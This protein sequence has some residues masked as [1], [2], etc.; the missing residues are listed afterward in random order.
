LA[1]RLGVSESTLALIAIRLLL[2]SNP[3]TS[4]DAPAANTRDPAT[5]RITIRL[6]PGD[7]GSVRHRA[8][9]RGFKSSAYLAGLVRAHL[10]HNPPLPTNETRILKAGVLALT[11]LGKLMAQYQRMLAEEGV[12]PPDL[13]QQLSKTRAVVAGVERCAHD[14]VRAAL[15][16]WESKYD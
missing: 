3:S 16:A 4:T 15:I 14:L 5:E 6:R 9:Q 12:L 10:A 11:S 13:A 2:D 8:A 1:A 7:A